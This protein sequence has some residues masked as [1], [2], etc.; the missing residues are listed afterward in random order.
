MQTLWV[1]LAFQVSVLCSTGFSEYRH[2]SQNAPMQIM[3]TLGILIVAFGINWLVSVYMPFRIR[4][5]GSAAIGLYKEA[6]RFDYYRHASRNTAVVINMY[7]IGRNFSM[8]NDDASLL[9]IINILIALT[10]LIAWLWWS[11]G[12]EEAYRRR[13]VV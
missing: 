11:L 3:I 10:A 4:H 7:L 5:A 2:S 13:Y 1:L 6:F 9:C 8:Y 12:S